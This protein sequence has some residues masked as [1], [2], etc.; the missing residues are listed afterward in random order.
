MRTWR[1]LPFRA[2]SVDELHAILKLRVDVFVVEQRCA[3][4]EID[5]QDPQATH[6]FTLDEQGEVIA[7]ARLL[8]PGD[9]GHPHIGRVVVHS[10]HRGQQL[11]R[12]VM[13][14]A[15]AR[16]RDLFGPVSIALSAQAHLHDLYA[17]L[18]FSRISE[19]YDWDGIP[20]IDM[21]LG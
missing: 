18:G 10:G 5:G 20:H 11:G 15:I 6:L 4:A 16:C 21:R 7:Y 9:D 17:S 2:L 12:A 14:E 8:P 1:C 13:V 3:Y 19:V